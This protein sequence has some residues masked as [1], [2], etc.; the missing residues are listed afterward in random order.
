MQKEGGVSVIICCYNSAG[1]L[2]ETLKHLAIQVVSEDLLWEIIVIDNASTDNTQAFAIS[3]WQKYNVNNVG[4]R[5]IGE[6]N[7]GKNHALRRGF[8]ESNYDFLITCDD[9]NWLSPGYIQQ[10][11]HVMSS[12]PEVAIFGGQGIYEPERPTNPLIT[13]FEKFY[14]NGPQDWADTQHWVYGAGSVCRK[15]VF[16]NLIA[17]QWD[18]VTPGRIGKKLNGGEDVEFCLAVFLAGWQIDYDEQLSQ[19]Y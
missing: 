4:F 15:Q 14:I 5:V 7:P 9:D 1:R 6:P 16:L 12:R 18:L 13:G 2:S 19:P 11:A 10:A 17:Q 8:N 3:E